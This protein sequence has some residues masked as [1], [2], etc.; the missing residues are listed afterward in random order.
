[1]HASLMPCASLPR[2]GGAQPP[3]GNRAWLLGV[4][5][6]TQ[7]LSLAL[8]ELSSPCILNPP[9]DGNC[10]FSSLGANILTHLGHV[11]QVMVAS[12]KGPHVWRAHL[13]SLTTVILELVSEVADGRSVHAGRAV[14]H[15]D[16]S[17]RPVC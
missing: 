10:A 2:Q 5:S 17:F 11:A 8:K 3:A 6:E 4:D 13:K 14:R 9:K 1:M 7:S 16:A 12:K 15:H